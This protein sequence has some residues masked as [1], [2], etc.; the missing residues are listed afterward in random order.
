MRAL[1]LAT[2]TV[3]ALG[4]PALAQTDALER[5]EADAPITLETPS[6]LEAK[7][8]TE[9]MLPSSWYGEPFALNGQDVVSF[10]SEG[11]PVAGS[12]VFTADYDNTEWRFSSEENR[13]EFLRD[14]VKYVPE[15]GGYCP[16]GLARGEL[17]VGTAEH[18]SLVG[19]KLYMN[20][21]R[22]AEDQFS[23]DPTGFIAAAKLNF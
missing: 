10:R 12:E 11:G 5:V 1:W 16:V 3:I 17:K 23:E 22:R 14:P 2:A 18:F 4:S 15:F 8:E 6:T 9:R 19:D 13:D 7:Q 21:H 20:A